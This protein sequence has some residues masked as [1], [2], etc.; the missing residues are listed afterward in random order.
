MEII[1][2]IALNTFREVLR[3][4][5]IYAFFVFACLISLFGILL[6][7]LS[8][9]QDIRIVEDLGLAAIAVIGGIIA[10]F[11]GANLVFKELERRTIY[12]IF[13]KPVKSWQFILGKY[14]GLASCLLIIILMMGG[15]LSALVGFVDPALPLAHLPWIALSLSLVYLELLFIIASASFFSTFSTPIMSVLFTLCFWLVGHSC[16]SLQELAKM[17]TNPLVSQFFGALYWLMPDLQS[18]TRVRSELMYGRA[19]SQASGSF[20]SDG[21]GELLTYLTTYILAYVIILLV[22]SA[23]VNER[24][25]LP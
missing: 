12:L 24:R 14:L 15:F 7:T 17:S 4:K 20:G 10:V 2:A 6:G 25:E 18:L 9:G 1:G 23:L 13:S 11:S 8:V 22:L 3:D 21:H 5:I 19:L 16:A